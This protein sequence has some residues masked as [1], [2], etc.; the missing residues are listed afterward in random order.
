MSNW[1]R[2]KQLL[3]NTELVYVHVQGLVWVCVFVCALCGRVSGAHLACVTRGHTTDHLVS[4]TNKYTKGNLLVIVINWSTT[5]WDTSTW[6]KGYCWF[7]FTSNEHECHFGECEASTLSVLVP[8]HTST[9]TSLC[10]LIHSHHAIWSELIMKWQSPRIEPRARTAYMLWQLV[11]KL[12]CKIQ[13]QLLNIVINNLSCKWLI[14]TNYSS[15]TLEY[16]I[17]NDI[18]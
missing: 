14:S 8:V 17:Y 12:T 11:V 7:C 15:P 1:P 9:W 16:G 13:C 18:Q 4:L 2:A 3:R 10:I 5:D 6:T